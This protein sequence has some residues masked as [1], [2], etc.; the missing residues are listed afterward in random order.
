MLFRLDQIRTVRN[1]I[2]YREVTNITIH[3]TIQT[4]LFH[5]CRYQ[6]LGFRTDTTD[7]ENT[8]KK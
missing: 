3:N 1:V 8:E 7:T 6:Q 5:L 4:I 2:N